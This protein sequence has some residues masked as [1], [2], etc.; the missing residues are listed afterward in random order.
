MIEKLKTIYYCEHCSKKALTKHTIAKHEPICYG[1]PDNVP[2]CFQ[3]CVHLEK[4]E[5]K[6]LRCEKF[7]KLLHTKGAE[8]YGLLERYPEQFE[9]SELMPMTCP[10]YENRWKDAPF[11]NDHANVILPEISDLIPDASVMQVIRD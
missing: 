1:N 3:E 6:Q 8:V 5:K 9:G 10:A 7:D 11:A 4:L 2:P